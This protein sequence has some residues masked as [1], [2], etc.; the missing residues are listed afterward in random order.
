MLT[1]VV[2]L[3]A[4]RP[5]PNDVLV[6]LICSVFGLPFMACYWVCGNCLAIAC[7]GQVVRVIDELRDEVNSAEDL[8]EYRRYVHDARDIHDAIQLLS[9]TLSGW[10]LA[11]VLFMVAFTLLFALLGYGPR[12]PPEHWF[13][14]SFSPAA[15]GLVACAVLLTGLI[16]IPL[17]LPAKV[18]GA[19]DELRSDLN[20]LRKHSDPNDLIQLESLERYIDYLDVGGLGFT[21]LKVRIDSAFM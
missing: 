17:A 18:T 15:C 19:C 10:Q 5:L 7:S 4:V 14:A 8:R 3:S 2:L 9:K 13:N 11:S 21:V 12:P 16:L 20:Q 1:T 6:A